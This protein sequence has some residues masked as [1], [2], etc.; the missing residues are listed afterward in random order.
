MPIVKL[1]YLTSLNQFT[2]FPEYFIGIS[3][4]YVL[5]VALILTYSVYGLIINKSLSEF[6]ALILIMAC[7]LMLND[8][9]IKTQITFYKSIVYDDLAKLSK[10][11]ICFFSALYFILISGS[12][13]EQ[14][15]TSFEYLL[16]ILFAILGFIL[17]CSSFDLLIIYLAI[18]L[19]S[20]ASY[21]L[22]SFRKTSSYSIESGLKYFITGAVS[23]GFFLLGSSLLYLHTGS[24]YL[25]D[26]LV[27]FEQ[28]KWDLYPSYVSSNQ[29]LWGAILV[30]AFLSN[31]HWDLLQSYPQYYPELDYSFNIIGLSFIF[32]GLLIKLACAPFHL[33]SL[34]VYE[35]SP[36]T[37]SFFF[38]VIS[39]LSIFVVLLRFAHCFM[40]S[41]ELWHNYFIIIGIFSVFI[42]S[43]GGLKQRRIKTLLAYSS[44]TNMGYASLT[45]GVLTNLAIHVLFF[46]LIIYM[47]SGLCLWSILLLIRL[48]VKKGINKYSKELGDLALMRK[49]N[50][51]LAFGL[52]L[53]MFSVAGIP[54]LVGFLSKMFVFLSLI[55]EYFVVV[56]VTSAILSTIATFYY[57]RVVKVVYFE[58]LLVGK[59]YYPIKNRPTLIISGLIL[60][61]IFLFTNPTML[62]FL[63]IYSTITYHYIV[64][65][66]LYKYT[67]L[68]IF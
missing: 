38:A 17:M 25:Q 6:L 21:L 47:I 58:N 2:L 12:L 55:Q 24:I 8:F 67:T 13:N 1:E 3:A 52:S 64:Q 32:Y 60:S 18:E 68:G 20:L 27:L 33:W 61:L 39:K 37:S 29:N 16:I 48:K 46:H 34:D 9:E 11:L 63:C 22:A 57:I 23:S 41:G 7:Y 30:E 14:K 31:L 45:L 50:S 40:S 43:F 28:N 36:T 19:S 10:F 59:L 15:L 66:Y 49:S 65:F 35:G 54:P 5:L 26:F 44:I 62:Q 53:S 56:V 51:A 42:G 4:I